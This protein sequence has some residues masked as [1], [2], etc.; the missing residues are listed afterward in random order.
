MLKILAAKLNEEAELYKNEENDINKESISL[1]LNP[2]KLS[3]LNDSTSLSKLKK[4][5]LNNHSKKDI[6]NL[7]LSSDKI[8]RTKKGKT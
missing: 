1:G 8:H 5:F 2:N 6:P 4:V 7:F 3:P